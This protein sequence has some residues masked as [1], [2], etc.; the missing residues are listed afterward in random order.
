MKRL[1][2]ISLSLILTVSCSFNQTGSV[3]KV[4]KISYVCPRD[5]D[6]VVEYSLDG[7]SAKLYDQSDRIYEL[8]KSVSASGVYYK[9][10]SGVSIH[11]K[12]GDL[13][14]EI[15]KDKIIE[16]KEFKK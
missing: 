3:K 13:L 5:T 15:V 1:I 11:E 2:I 9:N 4:K 12:N 6:F 14:V 7:K 16:C 10:S 8:K